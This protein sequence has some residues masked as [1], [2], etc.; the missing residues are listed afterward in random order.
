MRNTSDKMLRL[1][2]DSSIGIAGLAGGSGIYE[3]VE[4]GALVDS[5]SGQGSGS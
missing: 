2:K 4:L 3:G 1:M 5:V